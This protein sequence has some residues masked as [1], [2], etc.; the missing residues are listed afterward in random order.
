MVYFGST[1]TSA[2][3]YIWISPKFKNHVL[4]LAV[5]MV[6]VVLVGMTTTSVS[7]ATFQVNF[8]NFMKL[9]IHVLEKML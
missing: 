9:N 3:G 7:L 1:V 5:A 6:E 8:N 4:L 2:L